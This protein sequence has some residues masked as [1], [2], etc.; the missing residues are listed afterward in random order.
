MAIT[1]RITG[2]A[3]YVWRR[4]FRAFTLV[5]LLVVIAIIAVLISILLPALNAARQSAVSTNCLSNLKQIGQ[6]FNLYGAEYQGAFP[7]MVYGWGYCNTPG[8]P[9]D[10]NGW[11]T[12]SG[13]SPGSKGDSALTL[14]QEF[15]YPYVGN[16]G[17]V[18]TCPA[19]EDKPLEDYQEYKKYTKNINTGEIDGPFWHFNYGMNQQPKVPSGQS[20]SFRKL[21]RNSQ[22]LMLAMDAAYY[23]AKQGNVTP[24]PVQGMYYTPG[25]KAGWIPRYDAITGEPGWVVGMKDDAEEGRHRNKTLNVLYWD[26]HGG[27]ITAQ[28][29]VTMNISGGGGNN[30]FWSGQ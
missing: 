7:P 21:Y 10:L 27:T 13:F 19:H 11:P 3:G 22:V 17:K 25:C 18:F 23:S 1:P 26:G 24:T 5:E 15:L 20:T 2:R 14:W 6:A 28:D 30:L 8:V 4:G 29:L 16:S 12:Y 9:A